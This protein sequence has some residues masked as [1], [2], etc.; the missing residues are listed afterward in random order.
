MSF[1]FNTIDDFEIDGK[2][3][4]IRIDINSPVDPS[5]GTILDDTRERLH[6]ETLKELSNKGAKTVILAHQSRP[7]KTDFTTLKQHAEV[8]TDILGIHVK[9]VDS[10][11]SIRAKKAIRELKEGELLLLENARFFS[12]ETLQ[13]SAEEQSQS[14]M[15]RELAPLIDLFV[16][17]AFAAAHRS[18]VSLVGFTPKVPSAAGRV[19]EKELTI[20]EAA[21][22][23]VKKPCVF[24]IGGMKAD[25]SIMVMENVLRNGTA[26]TVITSGIIANILLWAAGINIQDVNKDFIK[27]KGYY[28][29]VDKSKKL[30]KEFP[31]QIFYPTD[32]AVNVDGE[33][34]D[35]PIE[36]ISNNSIFDIG[37]ETIKNYAKIILNAGTIFANGPA[38]VFEDPKFA[39]GTEDIINSIAISKG[40]SIIGG[41]H[42]AA[43]TTNLGYADSMDHVSSGGGACIT[44][45]AG[46]KLPAVEALEMSAQKYKNK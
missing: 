25:D 43:A 24:V 17:D 46:K 4:L 32:V 23:N 22:E 35:L 20:L 34:V 41:G 27:N 37:K 26:D 10:I 5:T 40:Y 31:N 12:E 44:L 7:G 6:A 9:Y 2:T 39:I 3:V 33:R 36:K 30:L 38:G 14:I 28:D 16:N 45:L 11:F 29:M 1:N 21:L 13:R 8:L 42:I 18:Q 15:V 19:M